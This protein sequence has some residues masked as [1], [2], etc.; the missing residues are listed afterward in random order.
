MEFGPQH[1][2]VSISQYKAMVETMIAELMA[3]NATLQKLQ[4]GEP[5]S[6]VEAEALAALLHTE[7]S[8]ITEDL[9]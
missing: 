9:L 2:S 6:E 5:V 8:H 4:R 7:H 3:H 1:E